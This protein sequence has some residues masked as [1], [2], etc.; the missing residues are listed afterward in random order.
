LTP[1]APQGTVPSPM[2]RT[3]VALVCHR[4][5]RACH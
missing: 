1:D 2:T 3:D 4:A 5:L